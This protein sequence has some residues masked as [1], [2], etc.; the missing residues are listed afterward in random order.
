MKRIIILVGAL[1]CLTACQGKN[2]EVSNTKASDTNQMVESNQVSQESQSI[3]EKPL[4]TAEQEL[5]L[6]DNMEKMETDTPY[7]RYTMDD[8]LEYAGVALPKDILVETSTKWIPALVTDGKEAQ[9]I[10]LTWYDSEQKKEGY[11]VVGMFSNL[12]RDNWPNFHIYVFTIKDGN[13][14]VLH[15]AQTQGSPDNLFIFEE[16]T[17]PIVTEM[18]YDIV[19]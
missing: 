14:I 18:F 8:N 7:Y 4:W 19:Q 11:Q 1:L 2:E 10:Q 13:P 15:S 12:T 6:T 9:P 3:K 5:Q 16:A 17:D